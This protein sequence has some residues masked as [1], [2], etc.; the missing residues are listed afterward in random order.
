MLNGFLMDELV[1]GPN[2]ENNNSKIV[3]RFDVDGTLIDYDGNKKPEIITLLQSF[4]ALGCDVGIW[5]GA[6]ITYAKKIATL[7]DL[8]VPVFEK[9]A[10]NVDICFDDYVVNLAKINIKIPSEEVE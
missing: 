8:K 2:N 9:K 5:S 4:Q 6:G 3:I 10:S 7:L 1:F